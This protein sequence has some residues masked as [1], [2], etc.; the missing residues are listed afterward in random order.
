MVQKCLA[1]LTEKIG[2]LLSFVIDQTLKIE[3]QLDP[4]LFTP[5]PHLKV[6]TPHVYPQI[7]NESYG[8]NRP[9]INEFVI[10]FTSHHHLR[11]YHDIRLIGIEIEDRIV[12]CINTDCSLRN[13]SNVLY[14]LLSSLRSYAS[15]LCVHDQSFYPTSV[16]FYSTF[17]VSSLFFFCYH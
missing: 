3:S 15:Y 4:V 13:A 17:M 10:P 6:N 14:R 1:K 16:S 7:G 11:L 2:E 5:N 8:K 9:Q 12:Q